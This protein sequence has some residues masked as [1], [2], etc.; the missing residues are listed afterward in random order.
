MVANV[1]A[2]EQVQS[3]GEQY[4]YGF[5]TDIDV[6]LAP[7]GLNEDIV[8]LISEKKGDPEWMLEWR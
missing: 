3:L 6:D 5:V 4:K 7:K 8:R 2:L 1:D